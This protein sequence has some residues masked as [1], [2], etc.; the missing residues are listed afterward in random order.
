MMG[1]GHAHHGSA[2][3][4]GSGWTA[5]GRYN[6]WGHETIY[7]ESLPCIQNWKHCD[8]D[9]EHASAFDMSEFWN[10]L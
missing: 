4:D 5:W 1:Y 10:G 6:L 7:G 9:E 3:V 8:R 2:G